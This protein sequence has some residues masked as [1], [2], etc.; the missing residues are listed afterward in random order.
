MSMST[1]C[2]CRMEHFQQPYGTGRLSGLL[3]LRDH[4]A[5]A[6][7]NQLDEIARSLVS[8]FAEKDQKTP[9]T[10]PT[11]PGLFT[12]SGAPAM[13]ADATIAPGHRRNDQGFVPPSS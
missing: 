5:P 1:A 13:P 3:Q 12:Y 7:Q 9:A 6:Y 4:I 10:L 11:V 2:R 8:M